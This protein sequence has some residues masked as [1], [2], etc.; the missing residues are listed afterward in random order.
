M[1]TAFILA[2]GLGVRLR[3]LTYAVPKPLLP[4]GEKPILEII[5]ENIKKFNI[6]EIYL[7]VNYKK[8]IIKAYFG[9]GSALGVKII[10]LDEKIKTGTAGSLK[11]ATNLIKDTFLVMNGDLLTDIDLSEMY[12]FHIKK[13]SKFTIAV[14][15]YC[16]NIP[17]GVLNCEEEVILKDFKEKPELK[18][19]INS[20]IYICEPDIIDL[21]D[22]DQYLD[23]PEL[24]EK[25][26]NKYDKKIFLYKFKGKWNDI[27]KF[28]E[29]MKIQNQ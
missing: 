20:G 16:V 1:Q 5:I 17:Y 26:Q 29:Y 6:N 8:E 23:M 14:R 10:Y 25:I 18:F 12:K 22:E 27:G 4:I 28:D 9:D 11:L 19:L 2:G 15:D 13:E 24:W 3:P 21:I 7:S